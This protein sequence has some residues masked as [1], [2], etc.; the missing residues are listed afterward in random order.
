MQVV[1]FIITLGIYAIYWYYSTLKELHVA[2]DQ[3]EGAGMWAVFLFI[4]ILN[5]STQVILPCCVR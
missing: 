5:A 2:N 1:L 4:P 3:D